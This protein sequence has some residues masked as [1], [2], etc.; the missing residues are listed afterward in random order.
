MSERIIPIRAS[1]LVGQ[2]EIA[3]RA[4]VTR[5]IVYRWATTDPR[6]PAPLAQLGPKGTTGVW[7]WPDVAA[8]MSKARITG[9]RRATRSRRDA[10]A[11]VPSTP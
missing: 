1:D 4:G 8:W 10:P 6:F 3:E 9:R 5:H 2:T 7:H 11:A